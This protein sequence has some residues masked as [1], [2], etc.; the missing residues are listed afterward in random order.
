MLRKGL[1][2]VSAL[3]L[4]APGS[5]PAVETRLAGIDPAGANAVAGGPAP[6]YAE[7][8][9]AEAGPYG[10]GQAVATRSLLHW[11]RLDQQ[12]VNGEQVAPQ[13]LVTA[14]RSGRTLWTRDVR[15]AAFVGASEDL[16]VVGD[17]PGTLVGLA[18]ADGRELWRHDTG[19][20]GM[21]A[22]LVAA[23]LVLV[24]Q[25]TEILALDAATGAPRW[26]TAIPVFDPVG[27]PAVANG[28][29]YVGSTC[30]LHALDLASG[31]IRF[32]TPAGSCEAN[33][34]TWTGLDDGGRAHVTHASTGAPERVQGYDAGTGARL[35]SVFTGDPPA[36]GRGRLFAADE[37]GIRAYSWRTGSAAA[38]WTGAADTPGT[39]LLVGDHLLAGTEQGGCLRAL[40]ARTG[41]QAWS[42]TMVTGDP[43]QWVDRPVPAGDLLLVPTRRGLVA[44]RSGGSAGGDGTC[45]GAPPRYA[46]GWD[47]DE[48][49]GPAPGTAAPVAPP[50]AGAPVPGGQAGD[51]GATSTTGPA[52]V[53]ARA[54]VAG[55]WTATMGRGRDRRRVWLDVRPGAS[56]AF[57]TLRV[58]ERSATCTGRLTLRTRRGST[59]VL[60]SRRIRGDRRR[61]PAGTRVALRLVTPGRLAV[62]FEVARPGGRRASVRAVLRR[63]PARAS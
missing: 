17:G 49:L 12:M 25:R 22:P 4:A 38:L 63:A 47:P 20:R 24:A 48:P 51:A 58:R 29:A 21:S 16:L 41:V 10:V 23:G 26:R 5:A 42:A 27:R 28:L 13:V 54:A 45:P 6:P 11:V 55:T 40:D 7:A 15:E 60:R 57:G 1:L 32:A 19:I 3:L 30:G 35:G 50:G 37:G 44:L 36:L 52:F 31:A 33:P 18:P 9:R 43:P 62:T 46:S 14:D 2:A 39:P 34:A 59:F 53:R 8:W 61:C 56:R